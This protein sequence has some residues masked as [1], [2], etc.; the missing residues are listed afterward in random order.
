MKDND[1]GQRPEGSKAETGLDV[2]FWPTGNEEFDTRNPPAKRLTTERMAGHGSSSMHLLK[3]AEHRHRRSVLGEGEHYPSEADR[4]A[5]VA[6]VGY[7]RRRIDP[8]DRAPCPKYIGLVAMKNIT[9]PANSGYAKCVEKH[10]KKIPSGPHT[11]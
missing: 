6:T 4:R 7:T 11:C 1:V 8:H 2:R 10:H 5:L 3:L 9:R